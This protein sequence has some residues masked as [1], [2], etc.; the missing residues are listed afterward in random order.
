MSAESLLRFLCADGSIRFSKGVVKFRLHLRN[1]VCRVCPLCDYHHS[2]LLTQFCHSRILRTLNLI[3]KSVLRNTTRFNL[4][5]IHIHIT[6]PTNASCLPF[7][8]AGAVEAKRSQVQRNSAGSAPSRMRNSV[9]RGHLAVTKSNR[10]GS[11]SILKHKKKTFSGK[12]ETKFNPDP[13]FSRLWALH[14]EIRTKPC[15]YS[16][17]IKITCQRSLC[18]A[19]KLKFGYI[20]LIIATGAKN[21]EA[22]ADTTAFHTNK[23]KNF[24][25]K[26]LI[27]SFQDGIPQ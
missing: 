23:Q 27:S 4:R 8:W 5:S 2:S 26:R 18:Q 17:T 25:K 11:Q 16:Q 3:S 21:S 10:F 24:W 9:L 20:W 6:N 12:N 19:T 22:E 7:F 15:T 14:L 1:K 13:C